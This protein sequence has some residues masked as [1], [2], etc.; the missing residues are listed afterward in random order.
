MTHVP[1]Y[2]LIPIV[3]YFLV[4]KKCTSCSRPLSYRFPFFEAL[5]FLYGVLLGF[6][7]VHPVEFTL[8]LVAYASLWVIMAIDY[9]V[10]LIPLEA[11][12]VL[13]LLALIYLFAIRYPVW[14]WISRGFVP[15]IDLMLDLSVA[16]VWY[17]LFHLLR[18]LSGYKMGAADVPLVLA[19]G[20]LL[21]HPLALFLP[22]LAA[23]LAIVFYI[24][25]RRSILLY[26]PSEKQIPF[27]VF[28]GMGYLIL[29]LVRVYKFI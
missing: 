18:I 10:L 28:L 7:S 1:W 9:R 11:I 22:G 20:L 15:N 5:A 14:G 17:F 25:R 2:G 21:G 24:L 27:G 4:N 3:G 26:A 16:F 23:M 19:L 13:L 12:F 8:L 29:A 6:A